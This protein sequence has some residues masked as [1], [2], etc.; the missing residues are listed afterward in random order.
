MGR[1]NA[2]GLT[3]L[4][5]ATSASECSEPARQAAAASQARRSWRFAHRSVKRVWL[6]PPDRVAIPCTV[7]ATSAAAI[8]V[9]VLPACLANARVQLQGALSSKA[10]ML[11]GQYLM[12]GHNPTTPQFA[13]VCCNM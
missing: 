8:P 2:A 13:P 9:S 7:P 10:E 5:R 12:L 11:T 4:L 1:R 6:P 3:A